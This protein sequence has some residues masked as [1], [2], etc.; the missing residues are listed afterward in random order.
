MKLFLIGFPKSGTSTIHTALERSGLRSAH[1]RCD[2]GF[3]GQIIY[4]NYYAARDPL[5]SLTTFDAITQADVC[6]P[7]M[8]INFWPNLDFNILG[9]I[10]T[11][12]PI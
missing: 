5:H 8:G 12:H 2:Q 3:V 11:A 6:L 4:E 1:W 9:A 10:L 7:A